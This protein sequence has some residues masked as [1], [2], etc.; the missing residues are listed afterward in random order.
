[1]YHDHATALKLGLGQW[2]KARDLKGFER[3]LQAMG[4]AIGADR[5]PVAAQWWQLRLPEAIFAGRRLRAWFSRS[6]AAR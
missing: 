4:E 1:M 2:S 3:E 5:G 6:P